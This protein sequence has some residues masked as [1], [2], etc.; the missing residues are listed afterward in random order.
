MKLDPEI[1]AILISSIAMGENWM[2]ARPAICLPSFRGN[3][4]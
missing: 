2:V 3:V 4:N 1:A